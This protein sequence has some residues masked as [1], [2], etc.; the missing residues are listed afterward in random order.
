[1]NFKLKID[2][3][4]WLPVTIL[5]IFLILFSLELTWLS[6][7]GTIIETTEVICSNDMSENLS[8][9]ET[10][11]LLS[12]DYVISDAD[13]RDFV[14]GKISFSIEKHQSIF[15]GKVWYI[16]RPHRID[17]DLK[18]LFNGKTENKTDVHPSDC[19]N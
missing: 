3:D 8:I 16:V 4:T 12:D 2:W 15:T 7:R 10:I 17:Y 18:Q 13:F 1:M 11:N 19:G 9:R 5:S 6:K 14:C